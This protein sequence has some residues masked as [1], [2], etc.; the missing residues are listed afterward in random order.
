MNYDI[1]DRLLQEIIQDW[2]SLAPT[3]QPERVWIRHYWYALESEHNLD[4]DSLPARVWLLTSDGL[5]ERSV[6]EWQRFYVMQLAQVWCH[7]PFASE[8]NSLFG[9]RYAIGLVAFAPYPTTRDIYFEVVWSGAFGR[10]SRIM[11]NTA[12]EESDRTT[13]WIA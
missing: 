4:Y 8:P 6:W 9:K 1:Q 13:L 12:A 3:F 2:Q 5:S 7:R 11:Y 10:G